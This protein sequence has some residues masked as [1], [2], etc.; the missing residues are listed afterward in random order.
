M[1]REKFLKDAKAEPSRF[2][3]NPSD[4]IRDRRLTHADRLEILAAWE[5]AAESGQDFIRDE[6]HRV[7][8]QLESGETSL[9]G[10]RYAAQLH[11]A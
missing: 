3:R 10:R 11:R 2:Y 4:V 6:L 5:R 8:E 1:K 9:P 7:R